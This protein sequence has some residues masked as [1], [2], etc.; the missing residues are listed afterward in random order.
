[1]KTAEFN[2]K[3]NK[4]IERFKVGRI[5]A[6]DETESSHTAKASEKAVKKL[7]IEHLPHPP[8]SQDLAPS[9]LQ[10]T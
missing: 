6:T 9:Y 4:W 7:W 1:M 2:E 8:S 5:S 10:S 3:L